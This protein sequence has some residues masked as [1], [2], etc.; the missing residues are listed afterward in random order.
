MLKFEVPAKVIIT[1]PYEESCENAEDT[2]KIKSAAIIT[3]E[4]EINDMGYLIADRDKPIAIRIHIGKY[5]F[6]GKPL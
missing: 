2:E 3:V 1:L 6:K 5:D 4:H